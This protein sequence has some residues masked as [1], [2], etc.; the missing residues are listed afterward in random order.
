MLRSY[1]YSYFAN[2]ITSYNLTKA[3][4]YLY[5]KLRSIPYRHT[6]LCLEA[7]KPV[8]RSKPDS[9]ISW[10]RSAILTLTHA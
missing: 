4:T 7:L 8:V 9:E 2:T 6:Y 1:L 5:S 3:S 10:K